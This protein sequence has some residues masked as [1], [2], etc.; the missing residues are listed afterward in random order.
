MYTGRGFLSKVLFSGSDNNKFAELDDRLTKCLQDLG[1]AMQVSGLELQQ[2]SVEQGRQTYEFISQ[3][4]VRMA[5]PG[6]IVVSPVLESSE[7]RGY[8]L[9]VVLSLPS[10]WSTMTVTDAGRGDE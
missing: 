9:L 5:W 8:L 10:S 2:K 1:A 4:C 3:V 7:K 6:E